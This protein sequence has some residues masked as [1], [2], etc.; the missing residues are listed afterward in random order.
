[1]VAAPPWA[2]PPPTRA[3]LSAS[4]GLVVPD[5][6]FEHMRVL[7]CGINPSLWSGYAGYHFARP[8]NRL[9]PTLHQA[10]FT[11]RRLH[12]AETAELEHAGLGIT[13]LVPRA[14]ARADEVSPAQIR[15]G[16][17]RLAVLAQRWQPAYVAVLGLGA[18]RLAFGAAA[19]TVGRQP[20]R[21]GGRPLWLLPN[22]SGL[23]AHYGQAVLTACFGELRHALRDGDGLR[24]HPPDQLR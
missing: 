2:P 24:P 16:R 14:T 4:Y 3:Q 6:L 23:N 9:W 10:G 21:V 15:A 1:M 17:D 7:L 12:P 8:S 22:P 11:S 19:A 18:Y 5:L 20:E 13:N